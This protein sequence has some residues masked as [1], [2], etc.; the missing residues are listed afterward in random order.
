M[1]FWTGPLHK[2]K[3]TSSSIS[4]GSGCGPQL[5]C[6]LEGREDGRRLAGRLA[7]CMGWEVDPQLQELR[8]NK[9]F[10]QSAEV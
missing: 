10:G 5:S 4:T 8:G 3:A 9:E 2:R 6:Q 7:F 1:A